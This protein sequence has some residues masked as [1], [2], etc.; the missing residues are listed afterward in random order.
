MSLASRLTRHPIPF[1]KG[2][3]ADALTHLPDLAPELRPLI[4]GTAG[5]SPYLALLIGKEAEWLAEALT[6]DPGDVQSDLLKDTAALER[7]DLESGLRQAKR[8]VHLYAA[9]ADLGGVWPLE[10]VT[11]LISDFADAA[12]SV[13]LRRLLVPEARRGK[14]PGLSEADAATGAGMV[15]IAM[16]K[17]GARELNYSSDIDLICL[18]DDDRF[19]DA[20]EMEARAGF[21]RVTRKM[22]AT[23]NDVTR[24]GYVFRTDLRLR[25]DAS[26][27]PVCISMTAAERYY[28]AEG[29]NWERAAYIKARAAAGDIAA[30]ERFLEI[31][32]PFVWRKH[33]DFAAIE[34]TQ[35]MRRK[36]RSHKGLHGPIK[37]EGHDMKLGPGGIR[38]IEFFAQT[39]QIVS[40]GRDPD[41]RLRG[42][43]PALAMLAE[44]D[45]IS[46]QTARELTDHY[47]AH[48]EIEHRVQMIHD[49]QTHD[50]PTN[51]DG[52]R[53]LANLC[54]QSDVAGFRAGL[55][56]RLAAVDALCEPFFKT[57]TTPAHDMPDLSETAEDIVARWP[58]YPALRSARG[59]AIFARLKPDI[60]ARFLDTPRPDE[61]LTNFDGFLRGLPAGVQLFALFEANPSLVDLLVDICGTAPGLSRH[62][63]RNSGVLDAVIGGGFFE[64]WPGEEALE[65]DLESDLE[66][67]DYEDVLNATRRWK[68][69]WHFRIGV[70]HLRGLIDAEEAGAQ[71]SQLASTI[72]RALWPRVAEEVARRHGPA[73]GKGGAVVA[74]GSL[75]AGQLTAGSDLDLIV[76]Y[77]ADGVEMSEGKRPLDARGW[78]AKA[79]KTLIT[80]LSAPTGDGTLYEVDMRLR[81]SG[82]QGPV[83]TSVDSYRNY[84]LGEAWT[85]EHLAL[86]R[87]RPLAGKPALLDAI[88]AV[89]VEVLTVTRDPAKV[90]A[91]AQD[92]RAR[93]A[94]AGRVGEGLDAKEGPGRMKDIELV[95]QAAALIAH[96]PRRD[97][98]AQLRAG[99]SLGWL[100]AGQA[101]A[102]Q[103]AHHLYGRLNQ[104]TRLLTDK[105]L[106]LDEIGLG[107]RRFLSRETD[108]ADVGE[109]AAKTESIRA[110]AEGIIAKA[111]AKPPKDA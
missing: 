83:A 76:I 109:L 68:K 105:R 79:T 31:L 4:E 9:L 107:G 43:V 49:T 22:A 95:A 38:E 60:L 111:M 92:M 17:M 15:A 28:E 27:T 65:A 82:R 77:D 67:L 44:K 108:V 98:A 5:C 84:H 48:R 47:R 73:P 71:Y 54:G 13:C 61:A 42:T 18:F 93:L 85:W 41:L 97:V 37:L 46:D 63:S 90:V 57:E 25:P 66:G 8:R 35:N 89:R 102:L 1:D 6:R 7:A 69:E 2:L 34:D 39:R 50:L 103:E 58:G 78:Y 11:G 3:G 55:Q 86:T 23:L 10:E 99:V 33:L 70:H 75:G 16:G 32:T 74:M 110:R 30:G 52:F 88:E 59:Q 21:I 91:D 87:A 12:V 101:D 96:C 53:R 36:I 26:V 72:I 62:L 19:D 51:E 94:A 20:D 100:E 45:W 24:E 29:R 40:G 106:D 64:A 104:A 81:P 80:A 14:I 56:E